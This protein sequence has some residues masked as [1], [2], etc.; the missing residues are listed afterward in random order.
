MADSL[1]LEHVQVE[2]AADAPD[3]APAA[4]VLHGRGADE[5]DLLPVARRLPDGLHVFCLRAPGGRGRGY[6]WYDLDLSGG[7]LDE[8]Q[9]D[10]GGLRRSLDLVAE[11]VAGATTAYGV[12]PGRLGLLGFSQGAVTSF[13]L[14]L[15]DPGTYAWCAGLHGYLPDSHAGLDPDGIGGTPVFVGAGADDAVIPAAR[16]EAAAERFRDLGCDVSAAVYDAGHGIGGEE[17]ADLSGWVARR[18]TP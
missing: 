13:A 18:V 14:L 12:D 6:A 9:P 8:S 3:P 1:P 10:P 5:R 15:E 16:A 11:F 2:P 4:F 17:L 7:G